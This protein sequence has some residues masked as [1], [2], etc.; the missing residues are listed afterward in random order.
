MNWAEHAHESAYLRF[1]PLLVLSA[2]SVPGGVFQ[3]AQ[4]ILSGLTQF[5]GSIT[6]NG[7]SLPAAVA[8]RRACGFGA[9]LTDWMD[10]VFKRTAAKEAQ[11]GDDVDGGCMLLSD[12]MGWNCGR[13]ERNIGGW[14]KVRGSSIIPLRSRWGQSPPSEYRSSPCS[15]G[16]C[17]I[18]R[19]MCSNDNSYLVG[20]Q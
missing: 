1:D 20:L 4:V 2:Q 7:S 3:S 12:Q 10:N 6:A 19:F 5:W 16:I 9:A 15:D 13:S 18:M 14:Q 17:M 8:L 11:S